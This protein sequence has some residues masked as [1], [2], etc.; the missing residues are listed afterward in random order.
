MLDRTV[1]RTPI[2]APCFS[3]A[4]AMFQMAGLLRLF[5]IRAI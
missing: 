2:L 1:T 5:N 4:S 3:A